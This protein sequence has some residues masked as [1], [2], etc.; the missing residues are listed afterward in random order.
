MAD[1]IQPWISLFLFFFFF[2]QSPL[3]FLCFAQLGPPQNI[4]T[5][6]PFSI[7]PPP[8]NPTQTPPLVPPST[9]SSPV[10]PQSPPPPK[11]SSSNNKIAKAV[12]A[13]AAST[14]VVTA[15]AFFLIRRWI[16]ARRKRGN[17]GTNSRFNVGGGNGGGGFRP[18]SLQ[19]RSEFV[20]YEGDLKG[21][22]VDENG[23]DVIYWRKLD[24]RNSLSKNGLRKEVLRNDPR[25]KE[26]QDED[27]DNENITENRR[28][29]KNEPIQEIPFLRGKSSTSHVKVAPEVVY[30][31]DHVNG[32][33]TSS[34][35]PKP[36]VGIVFKDVQEQE[37]HPRVS[38]V[39]PPPPPS[40]PPSPPPPPPPPSPPIPIP[41]K[42]AF[43][44]PPPPP[45]PKARS[46]NSLSTPKLPPP[47]G[48]KGKASGAAGA[49]GTGNGQVK[50]KPLHWD[51]VN[52]NGEHSMVWD[53]I[54]D[55]GSFR[56]KS[57]HIPKEREL[58]Q[59]IWFINV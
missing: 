56:Y 8:S 18:S 23:L 31:N 10:P 41:P 43:K 33:K 51:K 7:S 9:P 27:G 13:T 15:L 34:I 20:K 24:R 29:R 53:K 16:V 55:K 36:S 6:Y 21:F 54:N 1:K 40:P 50:L 25:V 57:N 49:S 58:K 3:F 37:F 4:E 39:S 59:F 12:A 28:S 45:A 47:P 2:F 32:T 44:P 11:S 26:G 48:L 14:L 17:G 22:I 35:P 30:S 52:T 42:I 46:L 38:S 5:F 19:S